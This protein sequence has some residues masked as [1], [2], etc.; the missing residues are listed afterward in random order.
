MILIPPQRYRIGVEARAAG[1][2]LVSN[3]ALSCHVDAAEREVGLVVTYDVR[4]GS[5]SG[6]SPSAR[7]SSV[8]V[9]ID[10]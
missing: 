7:R 10:H 3:P 8:T 5:L 4:A 6:T 2:P 1:R 9:V